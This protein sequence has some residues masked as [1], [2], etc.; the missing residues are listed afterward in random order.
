ME[1][2]RY[3]S[4]RLEIILDAPTEE[5]QKKEINHLGQV[6]RAWM[7]K[8]HSAKSCIVS[9]GKVS[10]SVQPFAEETARSLDDE[11]DL[12]IEFTAAKAREDDT[13]E[14][15]SDE[16]ASKMRSHLKDLIMLAIVDGEFDGEEQRVVLDIGTGLGLSERR[17]NSLYNECVLN[18]DQVDC[19][20]ANDPKERLEHLANLC[21]VMLADGKIADWESV[22]IFPLATKLGFDSNDISR[23]LEELGDQQVN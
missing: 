17:V 8:C 6:V 2:Q 14:P 20:P 3:G 9:L 7:R 10:E 22:L 21:R 15:G 4:D 16:E 18:P 13:D 1:I 5:G 12:E 11:L 23:M 19:V